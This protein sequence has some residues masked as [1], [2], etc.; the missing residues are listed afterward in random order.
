LQGHPSIPAAT[1]ARVRG[2]AVKIGY[3]PDLRVRTLMARISQRRALPEREI[4]AFVHVSLPRKEGKPEA[5]PHYYHR[6]IFEGARQRAEELGAV[7]EEFR[8][9][10]SGLTPL[11]LAQILR[12]RG[13]TGIIFSP[14]A[15]DLVVNLNWEWHH[16]ACAIIGNTEWVPL[17]HRAGHNHFRSMWLALQQL[18]QEGFERPAAI[19]NR[20]VHERIHG[21]HFAAFL[22]NHLL[23]EKASSLVQFGLPGEVSR[24][25]PWTGKLKPDALIVSWQVDAGGVRALQKIAP[26]ARR[27][28][29]LDWRAQGALAGMDACHE[30]IAARAVELVVAQLHRNERGVPTHP[31]TLL[32]DGIWRAEA[33]P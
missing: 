21:M 4:L 13:I 30:E 19:I 15:L 28:V 12:T 26:T 32:L 18:R 31:T 16:F 5:H 9:E 14:S 29:T 7:L 22:A 2:I 3:K 6:A 17:L 8:L 33:T 27:M 23:Q 24:L 11:R 25:R 10:E 20:N 1:V